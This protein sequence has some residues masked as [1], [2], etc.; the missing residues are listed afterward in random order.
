M[1]ALPEQKSVLIG[2]VIWGQLFYWLRK[3]LVDCWI[4]Q[5]LLAG[6]TAADAQVAQGL[7]VPSRSFFEISLDCRTRL[8]PHPIRHLPHVF[9]RAL[10][11]VKRK[12][13]NP[14]TIL[15]S[16]FVDQISCCSGKNRQ[17]RVLGGEI[18][19]GKLGLISRNAARHFPDNNGTCMINFLTLRQFRQFQFRFWK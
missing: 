16:N 14:S 4:A 2:C 12:S 8:G 13:V 10:P 17:N 18:T 19:N 5:G 7:L 1:P 6:S 11:K 3:S 15:Q 9:H